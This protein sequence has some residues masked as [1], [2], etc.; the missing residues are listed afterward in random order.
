MLYGSDSL[1]GGSKQIYKFIFYLLVSLFI[2]SGEFIF[3]HKISSQVILRKLNLIESF[4]L[5]NLFPR[6][7]FSLSNKAFMT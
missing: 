1:Y 4:V 2:L 3:L 6:F 7:F 5:Q